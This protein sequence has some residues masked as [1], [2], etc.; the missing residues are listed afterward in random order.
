MKRTSKKEEV[1]ERNGEEKTGGGAGDSSSGNQNVLRG[2]AIIVCALFLLAAALVWR[3][4]GQ[5]GES[6]AVS[7]PQEAAL[8][9]TA[10]E[11]AYFLLSAVEEARSRFRW[12]PV[13]CFRTEKILL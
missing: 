9:G 5:G 13:R 1:S 11:G 3:A 2:A 12:R 6:G 4:T 8:A 7:V 10:G